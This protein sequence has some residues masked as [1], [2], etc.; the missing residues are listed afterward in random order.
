M[1]FI[2]TWMLVLGIVPASEIDSPPVHCIYVYCMYLKHK[3]SVTM[4]RTVTSI[5]NMS[6]RLVTDV[7]CPWIDGK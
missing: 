7:Y 1:T 3:E 6:E 2:N 4:Y 5:L